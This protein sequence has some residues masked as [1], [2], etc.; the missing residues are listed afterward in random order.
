MEEEHVVRKRKGNE[1]KEKQEKSR[2]GDIARNVYDL[3]GQMMVLSVDIWV[4][5]FILVHLKDFFTCINSHLKI[6]KLSTLL[7]GTGRQR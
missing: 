7:N 5:C 6:T 3:R 4:F 1:N 2:R